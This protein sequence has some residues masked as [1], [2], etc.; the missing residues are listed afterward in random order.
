MKKGVVFFIFL[1]YPVKFNV[2][3]RPR[4][5]PRLFCPRSEMDITAGFGPVF[6]GSNPTEGEKGAGSDQ[7]IAGLTPAECAK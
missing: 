7:G 1:C 2:L 3:S 4:R 6:V 5:S